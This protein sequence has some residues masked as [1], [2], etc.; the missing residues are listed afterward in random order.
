MPARDALAALE[1]RESGLTGAEAS[2]RLVRYGPNRLPHQPPP[3]WWEIGLRQFQSPLIYIL[4]LAAVVSFAIGHGEDAGFI[5]VVLALNAM[6]ERTLVAAAVMG[7]VSFAAFCWMIEVAGWSETQSRN[8]L[9]LLMVLFQNLHI[10]NCRSETQSAFVLS[11][12]RSPILLGGTI[13]AFSIHMLAMHVPLAQRGLG[14]E[15]VG[16]SILATLFALALSIVIA[17]EIHKRWWR[18][19]RVVARSAPEGA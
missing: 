6:I 3:S 7:G 1:A 13:A 15:P 4:A 5:V 12:L 8:A 10:G 2:A 14:V 11:P 16:V 9:L 18:V 19:R 17:M